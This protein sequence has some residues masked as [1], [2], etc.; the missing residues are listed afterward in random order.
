MFLI[1]LISFTILTH[2]LFASSYM[3]TSD[4][5]SAI[6]N[7]YSDMA[8]LMYYAKNM[9]HRRIRALSRHASEFNA[10]K[11][12]IDTERVTDLW[13]RLHQPRHIPTS[14]NR[15]PKSHFYVFEL[16]FVLMLG[17]WLDVSNHSYGSLVIDSALVEK[18]LF[19]T[20][21]GGMVMRS[22][23]KRGMSCDHRPTDCCYNSSC[24]CNLWGTNCR[25]QRMGL[26]QKWGK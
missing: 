4:A 2:T 9:P 23:L 10:D 19:R 17:T 20:L 14:E 3:A 5:D 13:E 11:Q 26:F 6:L 18:H 21:H 24:R 7:D 8:R 25:C 12:F 16:G 15:I 1:F 22:C